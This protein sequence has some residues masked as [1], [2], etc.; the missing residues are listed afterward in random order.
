MLQINNCM[1]AY[2]YPLSGVATAQGTV[3]FEARVSEVVRA[4]TA[5]LVQPYGDYGQ[6]VVYYFGV[7]AQALGNIIYTVFDRGTQLGLASFS[8]RYG[9]ATWI[10]QILTQ[11]FPR[12]EIPLQYQ[13]L[14]AVPMNIPPAG[15]VI[16]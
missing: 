10:G 2:Y 7:Q 12:S 3:A 14:P 11:P 5:G 8:V 6:P 15:T 16:P 13:L 1:P 4:I 9:A